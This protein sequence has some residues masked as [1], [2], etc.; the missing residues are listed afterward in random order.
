MC[1]GR[2]SFLSDHSMSDLENVDEQIDAI[3][4]CQ[5]SV[6]IVLKPHPTRM[7]HAAEKQDCNCAK[8]CSTCYGLRSAALKKSVKLTRTTR[9]SNKVLMNINLESLLAANHQ[10][11]AKRNDEVVVVNSD[12]EKENATESIDKDIEE[13][14]NQDA[15]KDNETENNAMEVSKTEP[16][17]EASE[18]SETDKTD[19]KDNET[20]NNAMEVS[21]TEPNN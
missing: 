15:S 13:L 8:K 11:N 16:N 12:T 1:T 21:E 10:K 18:A 7:H 5:S 4:L 14:T 2:P 9:N 20:E 19:N 3:N 6:E 17:N